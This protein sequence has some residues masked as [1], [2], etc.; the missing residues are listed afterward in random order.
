MCHCPLTRRGVV[1]AAAAVALVMTR[2]SSPPLAAQPPTFK[3]TTEAVYVTATVIDRDGRLVTD[4]TKDDFEIRDNGVARDITIFRN[5]TV[6]FAIVIMLDISGSMLANLGEMR[7]GVEQLISRFEPGDRANIGTFGALPMISPRFTANPQTLLGW[8]S[9]SLGGIGVPCVRQWDPQ[10]V[11]W[12]SY[13]GSAIWDAVECGIEIVAADGETPRRVVMVITDGLDNVS[14]ATPPDL[15]R[16]AGQYG[17]M[18]YAVGMFGFGGVDAGALRALAEE[19]GGG[20]FYLND[21]DD[22][23]GTFARVADEL[24]HQYVFG[25]T[26]LASDTRKHDLQVRALRPGVT[27]RARRVY[28]EAA[29]VLA[30][31]THAGLPGKAPPP[32]RDDLTPSGSRGGAAG[33][34]RGRDAAIE[35]LDRYERGEWQD[36]VPASA[37]KDDLGDLLRAAPT[38]IRARGA[39]EE[40]RRRLAAASYLVEFLGSH[41]RDIALWQEGQSASEAFEWACSLLRR[42]PPLPA[43][44]WWHVASIALLE[45]SGA[46]ATLLRHLDH[47]EGRF[48][49]EPRW[50]LARAVAEELRTWPER[51]DES[52]LSIPRD[53][54]DRITAGFTRASMHET[55]KS[56]AQLRWGYFELR[57]GQVDAALAHFEQVGTPTDIHLRYW[58]HLFRGRALEQANRLKDAIASYQL[59]MSDVPAQSAA[60][61]LGAALVEDRRPSEAAALVIRT[62]AVQPAP[63]D[64]WDTYRSPDLRFWP[65]VIE[66]LHKAIVP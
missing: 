12:A 58:L 13:A 46:V 22:L 23:P 54:A 2:V 52:V 30:G 9:A 63:P 16:F 65:L 57:R 37:M 51:R 45:H 38:W 8:V 19:S 50:I 26:P 7:R 43:E 14:R 6:P 60:L 5:D 59:A 53:V 56:E 25:F 48:P 28:M 18:I 3:T 20:Y 17:V 49:D 24:R 15:N 62:L 64:P 61:A 55:L 35:G 11:M 4:L 39:G 47:A 33:A 27:T 32:A 29:P 10:R 44:R 34:V 40:S 1:V 36:A 21:S 42:G 66:E 31:T 41:A